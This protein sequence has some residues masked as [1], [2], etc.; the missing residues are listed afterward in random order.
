VFRCLHAK[1][2]GTETKATA[3]VTAKEEDTLW[4]S[5]VINVDT[6]TG[7]LYA[8]FFYNGKNFCL[9][10][11]A[12]HR[13]L[14]LSQVKRQ[15]TNVGGKMVNSY[16]YEEFGSKNNQ[17]GFASFNQKNKVVTQHETP[18]M[19]CHVKILDKYFKVLPPQSDDVFI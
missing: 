1:G 3:V 15:V 17:G 10:G 16:V 7:L 4:E 13:N 2:I 11:G 5:G 9:R 6:P 12:E 14:K 18:T 19:R 8:V